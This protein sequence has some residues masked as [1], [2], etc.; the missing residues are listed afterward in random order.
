LAGQAFCLLNVLAEV[1]E[2]PS[3]KNMRKR[4]LYSILFLLLTASVSAHPGIGIVMDS[5]GNVFYTD[6]KQV[7][8]ISPKGRKSI[9][10]ANVHT[11]ELYIDANDNLYGE[12]LWY[13]GEATD[14][15]GHYVWKLHADGKLEQVIPRRE[16]FRAEFFLSR[17]A[18]CRFWARLND[19]IV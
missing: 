11:H 3:D 13:E 2:H 9:A 19:Y 14:K 4:F 1:H 6:L 18:H 7:W 17:Q 10:A 16:G 8:K 15:W 12:H 5:R